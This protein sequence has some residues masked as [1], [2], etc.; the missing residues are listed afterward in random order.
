MTDDEP[1]EFECRHCC[2]VLYAW[3]AI[4]V[5]PISGYKVCHNCLD[6]HSDD[7]CDNL[8]LMGAD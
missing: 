5:C 8:F 2:V 1:I 4:W 3:D 6:T 7:C